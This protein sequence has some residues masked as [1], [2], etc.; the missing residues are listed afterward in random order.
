MHVCSPVL[1]ISLQNSLLIT[2]RK[3]SSHLASQGTQYLS[4]IHLSLHSVTC[5]ISYSSTSAFLTVYSKCVP[6]PPFSRKGPK[7]I[8]PGWIFQAYCHLLTGDTLELSFGCWLPHAHIIIMD[9]ERKTH[10]EN[11]CENTESQY[12]KK[13]KEK[14]N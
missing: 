10:S 9:L 11:F 3:D 5:V 12:Y 13:S 2:K 1:C 8:W 7:Q 14:G 4:L 6:K